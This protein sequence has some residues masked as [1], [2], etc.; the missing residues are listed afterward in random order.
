MNRTQM[1]AATL[2]LL[3]ALPAMAQTDTVPA[4]EKAA[5]GANSMTGDTSASNVISG[6]DRNFVT[7]AATG[8][9]LEIQSSRIAK[10]TTANGDVRTFASQMIIDHKKAD[11][12]LKGIAKKLNIAV[13]VKLDTEHQ[14]MVDQLKKAEKSDFDQK[15]I[16]IQDKSHNEAV[17]LFQTEADNG[18]NAELKAYAQKILPELQGHLSEVKTLEA[19][20]PPAATTGDMGTTK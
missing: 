19:N 9:M 7:G 6:S 15:Y 11:N 4:P 10:G 5:I 18:E 8:D 16:T 20:V 3:L 12:Q 2:G 1:L 14:A 17:N 13:P